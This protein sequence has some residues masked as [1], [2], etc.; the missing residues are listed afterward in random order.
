MKSNLVPETSKSSSG[1][2]LTVPKI[3]VNNYDHN[4]ETDRSIFHAVL[5][6]VTIS[7][8]VITIVHDLPA[9]LLYLLIAFCGDY[10]CFAVTDFEPP[11]RFTI[12]NQALLAAIA[13]IT[14]L[15]AIAINVIIERTRILYMGAL[16][17]LVFGILFALIDTS[18]FSSFII[19]HILLCF[20]L[21]LY[22]MLL[23]MYESLRSK[24]H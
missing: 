5:K 13:D 18:D 7:I 19:L 10:R 4:D 2:T 11:K 24:S 23:S 16:A 15:I 17:T 12:D 6:Y 9:I 20:I 8:I 21:M 22:S 3:T 1:T 14:V